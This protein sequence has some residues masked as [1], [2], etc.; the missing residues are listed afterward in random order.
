[1]P[2]STNSSTNS[3]NLHLLSHASSS[4]PTTADAG[5]QTA[6]PE[7]VLPGLTLTPY[8][9]GFSALDLFR[10]AC[11]KS[12]K[13]ANR[14]KQIAQ[15]STLEKF[16]KIALIRQH[17]S[18]LV[19]TLTVPPEQ[20]LPASNSSPDASNTPNTP[21]TPT[22]TTNTTNTTN[23]ATPPTS[24]STATSSVPYRRRMPCSKKE[25]NCAGAYVVMPNGRF[26]GAHAT[27]GCSG[28]PVLVDHP[29]RAC[30]A[31]KRK[32]AHAATDECEPCDD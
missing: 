7:I 14:V 32:H 17:L 11:V 31:M 27:T 16:E 23:A 18:R 4:L 6:R 3:S 12:P 13:F 30:R 20:S 25:G 28:V 2:S 29:S 22:N 8:E 1:M 9:C 21:N 24:N 5:T 10:L 26:H 19:S 15:M